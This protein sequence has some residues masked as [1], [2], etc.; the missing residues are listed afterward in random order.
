MVFTEAPIIIPNLTEIKTNCQ[1]CILK[2]NYIL[3][4]P[5]LTVVKKKYLEIKVN[6]DSTKEIESSLINGKGVLNEA[7]L[8]C[9]PQND[10]NTKN[11]SGVPKVDAELILLHTNNNANNNANTLSLCIPVRKGTSE[12]KG[13][14]QFDDIIK[15]LPLADSDTVTVRSSNN[16]SVN[17][18]IPKSKY[19]VLTKT[20]GTWEE[21]TNN[22]N[23]NIIIFKD[24][25]MISP[26]SFSKLEKAITSDGT[27][28]Q[29]INPGKITKY[30]KI[31][32]GPGMNQKS[33]M[34][35][36]P[37]DMKTGKKIPPGFQ[38]LSNGVVVEIPSESSSFTPTMI[39]IGCVVV[40]SVVLVVWLFYFFWGKMSQRAAEAVSLKPKG[41]S[42]PGTKNDL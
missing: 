37:V 2:Y 15:S 34:T 7:R 8:Y 39:F 14:R 40:A 26:S 5:T 6:T 23:N 10:Y 35:C 3:G 20:T 21:N 33:S 16:F 31:I 41:S 11:F 9:P 38:S 28:P 12:T 1:S 22:D 4:N 19:I 24:A 13:S 32:N 30:D 27:A 42:F 36:Y 18:F 17:N 29:N 25:I